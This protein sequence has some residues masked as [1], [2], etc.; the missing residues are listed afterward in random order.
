ME[1]AQAFL[2][3]SDALADLLKSKPDLD[4]DRATQFKNWTINDVIVHL[5]FWNRAADLALTDEA[6][7]M[8]LIKDLMAKLQSGGLRDF[9]NEAVKQRGDALFSIWQSFYREM[10]ARWA[11]VDPKRRLKW[12][13]PEMSARSSMT[14]R[15]M[16][17]WAHGQEVFD[18]V[19]EFREDTD[20]IKNIVIMGINTFGWSYKVRGLTPPEGMPT[21][22]L[23]SPS[24]QVWVFGEGEDTI[25]GDAVGFAQVVTQTR[26]VADTNLVCTGAVATEW[27]EHAQCFA[28][29]PETPPAKGARGL[30]AS[31]V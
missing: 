5:H 16:E 10:A 25:E 8:E 30:A 18:L 14:A 11:D 23:K 27:M 29:P 15:Q 7:F 2:E 20:R 4:W 19:G 6:A 24:G 28:G 13:G 26:N 31:A 22:K 21:V 1:Q 17:T 9:E 3:E 12:A